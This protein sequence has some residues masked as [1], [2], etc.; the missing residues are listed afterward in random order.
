M[1]DAAYV[2]V[3]GTGR[4]G[5][6][7]IHEVLARHGQV[8]FVSNID[9]RFA[10]LDLK[11]RF[12]RALYR[13]IP[14][15]FTRK[16]GVRYAPSE[17]Y[18]L[19]DRQVSP[20]F[21]MPY[22]DL[23]AEDVTPW[24]EQRFREFFAARSQAQSARIFLHKYTGW[25][26]ARFVDHI[27]PGARFVNVIR[28]GRAVANSWLQMPWWLG[29]QGPE[30]WHWGQL[31]A[32]YAEEWEASGRSFVVLAGIGWKILMDAFE[33]TKQALPGDRWIDVRYEDVLSDPKVQTEAILKFAGLDWTPEFG[34][35]FDR[36]KFN[37]DR[38]EAFRRDLDSRNLSAL[39]A[40]LAAH[41]RRYG[42]GQ[43]G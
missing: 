27:L 41:L 9:D 32:D 26:R 14:P 40:S 16:G 15:R 17:A 34:K 10:R 29:Y 3:I 28:D 20:L 39:D 21:S 37:S 23:T 2:F 11:G 13:G 25:P 7:L 5:S 35:H 38:S 36:F 18:R 8:G 6:T 12:N 43:I 19:L 31:P 22:R 1:S 33:Q 42:Y 4:C 24:L 30:R